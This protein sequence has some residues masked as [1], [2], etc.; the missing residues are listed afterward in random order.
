MLYVL[1]F[2][3][4]DCLERPDRWRL[5]IPLQCTGIFIFK[6]VSPMGPVMKQ[7]KAPS[8]NSSSALFPFSSILCWQLWAQLVVFFVE[9]KEKKLLLFFRF[10]G[11]FVSFFF[12][13]A[14]CTMYVSSVFVAKCQLLKNIWKTVSLLSNVVKVQVVHT[15]KKINIPNGLNIC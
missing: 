11:I 7:W 5:F 2:I 4:N 1:S 10:S 12:K 8:S 13:S 14:Q 3:V 15:F 9:F 6:S